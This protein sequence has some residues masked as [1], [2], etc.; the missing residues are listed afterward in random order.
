MEEV[1]GE[2]SFI[3]NNIGNRNESIYFNKQF[4]IYEML[5]KNSPFFGTFGCILERL[6]RS[7][8]DLIEYRKFSKL[9]QIYYRL[10]K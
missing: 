9:K 10:K 4:K 6:N 5:D 1:I 7:Y 3:I 2:F 8:E